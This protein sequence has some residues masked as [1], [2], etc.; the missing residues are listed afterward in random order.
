MF[1]NSVS[2]FDEDYDPIL[3][4]ENDYNTWHDDDPFEDMSEIELNTLHLIDEYLLD[5]ND[6]DYSTMFECTN[7]YYLSLAPDVVTQKDP[8]FED[9]EAALNWQQTF[10]EDTDV[11][12]LLTDWLLCFMF[13]HTI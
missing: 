10:S 2:V 9:F 7:E 4:A 13:Y 3:A 5:D 8:T 6:R 1:A 12:Y 11:D